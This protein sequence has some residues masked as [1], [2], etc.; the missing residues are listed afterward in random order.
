MICGGRCIADVGSYPRE[1]TSGNGALNHVRKINLNPEKRSAYLQIRTSVYAGGKPLEE[2]GWRLPLWFNIVICCCLVLKSCLILWWPH[3]LQPDRILCPWVSPGKHT[4]AG[5]HFLLQGIFFRPRDQ[6]H[7]FCNS[8]IAERVFTVEPPGKSKALIIGVPKMD[9]KW[10][11]RLA[12]NSAAGADWDRKL[13]WL[14]KETSLASQ[15]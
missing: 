12:S 5:C 13:H 1:Q 6:I 9:S 4:G 11:P 14:W 7:V 3:G 15:H 2:S 8:C 10:C